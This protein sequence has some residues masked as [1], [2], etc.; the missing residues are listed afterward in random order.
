MP[1]PTAPA[2][3]D[4]TLPGIG[5]R[6]PRR[7]TAPRARESSCTT[8]PSASSLK[9]VLQRVGR[10]H[11]PQGAGLRRLQGRVGA[12][13]L[14][15]LCR[16]SFQ[17]PFPLLQTPSRRRAGES[18]LIAWMLSLFCSSSSCRGPLARQ[19]RHHTC[20][21]HECRDTV[22]AGRGT[23]IPPRYDTG[24][25]TR[26]RRRAAQCLSL[27]TRATLLSPRRC[28]D[29]PRPDGQPSRSRKRPR[30]GWTSV[31]SVCW[32]PPV[33]S[34]EDTRS[35]SVQSRDTGKLSTRRSNQ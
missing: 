6:V 12:P 25:L 31:V 21:Q 33:N 5:Q 10:M 3:L 11:P 17:L 23:T 16:S 13:Q 14:R 7:D 4:T 20:S 28:S 30:K 34:A 27:W 2:S 26:V 32:Q 24:A 1:Q 35:R 9:G 29:R 15:L 18:W 8:A 22:G 19:G